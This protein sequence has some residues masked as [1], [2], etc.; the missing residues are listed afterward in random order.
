MNEKPLKLRDTY[1][2]RLRL[3]LKNRFP[4]FTQHFWTWLTGIALRD[5]VPLFIWRPWTRALALFTQ[6]VLAA[7]F[8]T[9]LLNALTFG[10]DLWT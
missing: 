5:Q 9:L 7:T 2:Q 1:P 8:G 4:A 3:N 6:V 10:G